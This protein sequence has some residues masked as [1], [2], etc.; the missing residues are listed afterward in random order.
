MVSERQG[1]VVGTDTFH[2]GMLRGVA[3]RGISGQQ[4]TG[5]F[6][7]NNGLCGRFAFICDGERFHGVWEAGG[8][9]RPWSGVRQGGEVQPG[10]HAFL[11]RRG[12]PLG[13]FPDDLVDGV[14]RETEKA[15]KQ[16]VGKVKKDVEK[17]VNQEIDKAKKRVEQEWEKVQKSIPGL[18]DSDAGGGRIQDALDK[19][20]AGGGMVM[21]V[22]LGVAA[23]ALVVGV[24]A[25]AR[26]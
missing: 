16:T 21:K 10:L 22:V 26:R 14:K 2:K 20:T 3:L 19:S 24:V 12:T 1:R 6:K 4:V 5:E 25:V 17:R 13:A 8:V 15:V 9:R 7:R 11:G 18:P 23:V